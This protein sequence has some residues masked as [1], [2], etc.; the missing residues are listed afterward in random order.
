MKK[1]K[2]LI[3]LSLFFYYNYSHCQL[4]LDNTDLPMINDVQVTTIVDSNMAITLYPGSS[5]A[6]ILWDFSSLIFCCDDY[7]NYRW[8]NP[9]LTV[10]SAFFPES[11]IALKTQCYLYHDWTTHIITEM[12]DN[13]DYYIKDTTGLKYYGSDFPYSHKFSSFRFL[14]PLLK[15]GQSKTNSCRIVIQQSPDSVL[16][17]N[18]IDSIKAD[19]WGTIITPVGTY[20]ALRIYTK[21]IVWDSLYVNGVGTLIKYM[22]DNYYYKW[23]TKGLGF[24]V[25]QISKGILEKNPDYQIVRASKYKLYDVSVPEIS[26]TFF[27]SSVFPNPITSES[28][29]KI[30][31]E[32]TSSINIRISNI[33]GQNIV[34]FTNNFIAGEHNMLISDLL[35]SELPIGIYF[36]TIT[37]W[38]KQKT[39]KLIIK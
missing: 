30:E 24:P 16:I 2:I 25:L 3:F 38:D 36:I 39:L 21:E 32:K 18:I 23:Y 22:P 15:Y 20:N 4:V 8:T 6:N 12:C 11:N 17:T 9:Q 34:S 27:E 31:L 1:M 10:N 37:S 35:K 26:Q 14:F 5:G 28:V 19:G 29:L 33:F 7:K 13:R